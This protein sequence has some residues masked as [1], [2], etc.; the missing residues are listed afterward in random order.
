MNN[1]FYF[2]IPKCTTGLT[3]YINKKEDLKDL[4]QLPKKNYDIRDE[5]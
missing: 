4:K 3:N 2:L 1:L 5:K